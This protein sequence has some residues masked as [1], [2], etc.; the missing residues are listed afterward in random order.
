[1]S[2]HETAGRKLAT[3]FMT[4]GLGKWSTCVRTKA[5]SKKDKTRQ[6]GLKLKLK[7]VIL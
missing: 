7:T 4:S 5:P 2:N 3:V 1:M 6:I